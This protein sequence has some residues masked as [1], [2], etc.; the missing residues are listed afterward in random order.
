MMNTS[1]LFFRIRAEFKRTRAP[2]INIPRGLS[3]DFPRE[4]GGV[5]RGETAVTR[6]APCETGLK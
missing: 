2:G 5:V 6:V 1:V 4:G 3:A